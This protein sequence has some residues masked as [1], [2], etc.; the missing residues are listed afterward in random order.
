MMQPV[1]QPFTQIHGENRRQGQDH[2]LAAD[3][4]KHV[5]PPQ[6]IQTPQPLGSPLGFLSVFLKHGGNVAIL[7]NARKRNAPLDKGKT[8]PLGQVGAK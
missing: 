5:K 1:F 4:P 6:H 7:T 8:H 2:C 3:D